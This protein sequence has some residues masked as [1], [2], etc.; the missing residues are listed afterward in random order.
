ML[1]LI[2]TVEYCDQIFSITIYFFFPSFLPSSFF[3]FF[4]LFIC[5]GTL[6]LG[7]GVVK[8]KC[9]CRELN[10]K[11]TESE[12]GRVCTRVHET[13]VLARCT[14]NFRGRVSLPVTCCLK[15]SLQRCSKW[16]PWIPTDIRK[17]CLSS[18][19]LE[20][21]CGVSIRQGSEFCGVLGFHVGISMLLVFVT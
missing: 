2:L 18:A 20:G 8:E 5:W 7:K 13:K 10:V 3:I 12:D 9:K 16:F 19:V 6:I 15:F 14:V 17:T 11:T 21:F 1:L 4:N